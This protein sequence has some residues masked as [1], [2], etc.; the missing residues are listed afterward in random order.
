MK[1]TKYI[2]WCTLIIMFAINALSLVRP[3]QKNPNIIKFGEVMTKKKAKLSLQNFKFI[4]DI[5]SY[6]AVP[7]CTGLDL[8]SFTLCVFMTIIIMACVPYI[9]IYD[10][11][12]HFFSLVMYSC[13]FLCSNIC[14]WF[15]CFFASLPFPLLLYYI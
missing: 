10:L 14:F 8:D 1:I 2:F 11:I 5:I 9:N 4:I 15:F 13:I 6:K 12:C 7:V 3:L